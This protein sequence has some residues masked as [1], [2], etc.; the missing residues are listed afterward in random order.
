M[1]TLI[2]FSLSFLRLV[3]AYKDR[4]INPE[5][6]TNFDLI[7]QNIIDTYSL[8][9]NSFLSTYLKLLLTENSSSNL[10][11]EEFIKRVPK[12]FKNRRKNLSEIFTNPTK[13]SKQSANLSGS[14]SRNHQDGLLSPGKEKDILRVPSF[15]QFAHHAIHVILNCR[16]NIQCLMK[17]EP[18][19]AP[20]SH[21]CSPCFLQN[22]FI[23]KVS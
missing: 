13:V 17:V 1:L 3:S 15:R 23:F 18:H 6:I 22:D 9:S 16:G 8:D 20:Y 4:I 7:L 10:S 12:H 2:S 5:F 11:G 14:Y 19:I 21:Y